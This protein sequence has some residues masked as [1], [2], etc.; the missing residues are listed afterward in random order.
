M[1]LWWILSLG[2]ATLGVGHLQSEPALP[3]ALVL[4]LPW[5]PPHVCAGDRNGGGNVF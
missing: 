1:G 4:A 2:L 5:L 3:N